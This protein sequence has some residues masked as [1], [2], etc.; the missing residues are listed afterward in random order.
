MPLS[1][2]MYCVATAFKMTE[3]GEWWICIKFCIKLEHPSTETS[4]MIQKA[5]VMEKPWLAASSPQCTCSRITSHAEIFGET[6]NHPGDLILQQLRFGA[7][8]LLAFPKTK[9]T[10]EREEISD[11]WGDS[12]KDDRAA[13]GDWENCVRSGPKVPTLKGTEVSLSCVQCFLYLISSSIN[14]W[15]PFGQ[16]YN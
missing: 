16:I 3:Q 4:W 14:G 5:A 12:G 2:H 7:L 15:V 8:R 6:S 10:F 11:H 9:V 13:G 1:E